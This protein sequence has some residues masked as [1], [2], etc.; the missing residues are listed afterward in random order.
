MT[1][2]IA[3]GSD[4]VL[5]PLFSMLPV[6]SI[7]IGYGTHKQRGKPAH[8]CDVN[9]YLGRQARRRGPPTNSY[10]FVLSKG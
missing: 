4:T 7:L 1:H 3:V 10:L 9:V 5:V 2:A 6:V 8:C